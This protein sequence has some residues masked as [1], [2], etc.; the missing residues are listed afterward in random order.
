ME[1]LIVYYSWTRNNELL[2]KALQ[3]KLHCDVLKIEEAKKRNGFSI[4]LDLMFNR[5]SKLK[6]YSQDVRSYDHCIL[7]S[8]VWAGRI[9]TPMRTFIHKEKAH[10]KDYSF[11]SVCGGGNP[12]QKEKLSKDLA[13]LL[14]GPPIAICELWVNDLLEEKKKNTIKYVTGYKINDVDLSKFESRINDFL[15]SLRKEDKKEVRKATYSSV[16]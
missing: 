14:M 10:V 12:G 16:H 5:T 13:A 6:N 8:P 9:A 15:K 1:T 2:A 4:M 11:I 7:I 3:Q